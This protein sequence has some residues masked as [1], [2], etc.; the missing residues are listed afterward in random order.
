[1]KDKSCYLVFSV[2]PSETILTILDSTGEPLSMESEIVGVVS[3]SKTEVSEITRY[4]I[5]IIRVE[6]PKK[7]VMFISHGNNRGYEI[8]LYHL[9]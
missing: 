9:Y 6:F 4:K 2:L 5:P 7:I 8:S 1:M 3:V